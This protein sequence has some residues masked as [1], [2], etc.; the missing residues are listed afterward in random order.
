[1]SHGTLRL[2]LGDQ[3]SAPA[4]LSSLRDLDPDRDVVLMAEVTSELTYVRH[5][6]Q[7]IVHTLS[8]MR[9]HAEA[10]AAAGITV[11][12]VRYDDPGNT[13]SLPTEI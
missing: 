11:R 7:K 5:H 13:G 3:L 8:A 9:L 2:V 4:R 6:K 10:L 12:Y 1:M